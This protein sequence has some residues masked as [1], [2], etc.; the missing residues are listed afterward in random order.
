MQELNYILI[1]E[2]VERD[3]ERPYDNILMDL[4]R[5]LV[6]VVE[7]T[8]EICKMKSREDVPLHQKL[9]RKKVLP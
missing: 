8:R 4:Q 3:A 5:P 1:W 7:A 2:T 6:D 9:F